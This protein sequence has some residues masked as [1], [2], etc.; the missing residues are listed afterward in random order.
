MAAKTSSKKSATS[1]S[2]KSSSLKTKHNRT[3]LVVIALIFL[4]LFS[5]FVLKQFIIA[6][7]VN[8]QPISRLEVISA[9][10]KQGGKQTLDNMITKTL[11]LQEGKKRNIE[12]SQ[13]EIEAEIQKINETLKEQQTT[14]EAALELQGMTRKELDED[15]RLQLLVQK[16]V[17]SQVTVGDEEVTEYV[18]EN[19]ELFPD[20]TSEEEKISQAREQLKAQK[21]QL[22]TQTLIENLQKNSKTIYFVTY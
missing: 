22:E 17:D 1:A 9:L 12:V 3:A 15:I 14:L 18:T 6:A 10:E 16:L 21:V 7:T 2:P 4:G 5:L 8:G 20:S 19:E 13:D 11:I